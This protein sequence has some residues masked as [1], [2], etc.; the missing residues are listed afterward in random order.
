[1]IGETLRRATPLCDV[2]E[3]Q[4]IEGLRAAVRDADRSLPTDYE[5]FVQDPLA[6]WIETHLRR[7]GARGPPG[8]G[9]AAR[10]HERALQRGRR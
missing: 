4:C 10:G 5:A 9:H 1:M 6:S 2:A 8:A 3:A 7:D